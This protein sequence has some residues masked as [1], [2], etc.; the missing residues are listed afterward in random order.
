M[1]A[2]S[3]GWKPRAIQ[4]LVAVIALFWSVQAN[5]QAYYPFGDGLTWT[6]GSGETQILQGPRLLDGQEVLVL[7]HYFEGAPVSEDY[8]IFHEDGSVVSVGTASGGQRF[9]YDPPLTIWPAP[10]LQPNQTWQTTTEVAGISL[11]LSSE[12]L[13]LQ[14]V[15]TSAGRFNA[16]QVRQVTLTSSGAR[17]VLD[18][19]FVP[20]VGIVRFVSQDGT[21]V[22]LIDRNFD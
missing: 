17:T 5:A 21:T 4:T 19:F 13:G 3:L 6:Y 1:A 9:T 16:F 15:R 22:D 8:L 18:L 14:G 11:T 2:S 12:V 20:T 7:T 10:P